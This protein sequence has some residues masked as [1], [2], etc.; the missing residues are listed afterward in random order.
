[1]LTSLPLLI[2]DMVLTSSCAMGSI[3]TTSLVGDD[4]GEEDHF[5]SLYLLWFGDLC[6]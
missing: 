6:A 3:M 5:A 1:M 2:D 4:K